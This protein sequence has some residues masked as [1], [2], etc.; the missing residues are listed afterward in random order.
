MTLKFA[1]SI[2]KVSSWHRSVLSGH[3]FLV[4]I[5]INTT[6]T[7]TIIIIINIVIIITIIVTVIVDDIEVTRGTYQSLLVIWHS[8]SPGGTTG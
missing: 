8:D 6:T 5:I 4:I 7:A 3:C 1:W 2:D